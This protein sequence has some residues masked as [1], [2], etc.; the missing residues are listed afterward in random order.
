MKKIAIINGPNLNLTGV[1]LPEIYGS[2]SFPDFIVYLEK[3][4][5][6]RCEI[7]YFQ[8]NIE[9]ELINEIQKISFTHDALIINAGAYSHTSIAIADA[10][11]VVKGLK[12]EVHLSNIFARENYRHHS[13]ISEVCSAVVCGMG[14]KGYELIIEHILKQNNGI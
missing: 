8:S 12:Y 4:Y 13:Y 14:L 1:R 3:K 6:D 9:G 5:L 11:Q 2:T 7:Y 10:L